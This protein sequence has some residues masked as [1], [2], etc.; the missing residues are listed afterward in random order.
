MIY[1]HAVWIAVM[2]ALVAV[3]AE[4]GAWVPVLFGS[5]S[6]AAAAVKISDIC[7]ATT[8]DYTVVQS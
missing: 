2:L 4:L 5:I 7:D 6:V 3:S 8:F 1:A